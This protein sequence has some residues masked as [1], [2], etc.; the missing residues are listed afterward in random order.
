MT[1]NYTRCKTIRFEPETFVQ[2]EKN[3]LIAE[4]TTSE[5]I[6]SIVERHVGHGV[7]DG[8]RRGRLN[9]T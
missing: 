5:Y 4:V 9:D 2:I 3:A 6:R 1:G 8:W 7:G